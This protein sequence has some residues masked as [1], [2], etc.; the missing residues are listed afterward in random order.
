MNICQVGNFKESFTTET[1][2]GLTL[3]ALGHTVTRVQEDTIEPGTLADHAVGHDIVF[4]TRTWP[5]II[6]VDDLAAVRELGIPSVSGHLDTYVGLMREDGLDTDAFWR[7]D[8][9][10][11]ADG[12]PEA[13]AVFSRKG[14]NHHWMPAGVYAGECVAGVPRDEYACDVVF[15]GGGAG[16]HEQDWPYRQ[17]L[18]GWLRETYG[19]RFKKFGY[20]EPTVRGQALNDLYASAKVVVGDSLCLGFTR[21]RY[22]SDRVYETTGRGGGPL[23]HPRIGGLD[24]HF[25]DGVEMLFYDFGDFDGLRYLI[26]YLLV[27]PVEAEAIRKAGMLRTIR[28]HTYARRLSAM[29]AMVDA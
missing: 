10:F 25:V 2:F 22:W 7:T 20:P 27:H 18:L 6:T 13:A 9:V 1:H 12:S 23:I 4:W 29:L 17:Q 3:E 5:G 11:S 14:I 26:D 21:S 24:E 15:V 28:D 16:Y 19:D 8:W